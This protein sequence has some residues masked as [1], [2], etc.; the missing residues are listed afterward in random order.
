MTVLAVL[1]RPIPALLATLAAATGL[2]L[3]PG[4]ALHLINA[5]AA[6]TGGGRP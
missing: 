6:L 3:L 4:R 5:L 2:L 1:E